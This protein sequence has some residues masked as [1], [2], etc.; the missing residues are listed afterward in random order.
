MSNFDQFRS[1]VFEDEH[2]GKHYVQ[3]DD[4]DAFDKAMGHQ[5]W[6]LVFDQMDES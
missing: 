1:I 4:L 2:G 6:H 3:V 5:G